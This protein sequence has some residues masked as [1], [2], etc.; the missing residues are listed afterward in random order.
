MK[1]IKYILSVIVILL[2]ISGTLYL[3]YPFIPVVAEQN[4]NNSNENVSEPVEAT[5]DNQTIDLSNNAE[6]VSDKADTKLYHTEWNGTDTYKIVNNNKPFFTQA[7]IEKCKVNGVYQSYEEYSNLDELGRC[8]TATACLGVD[9]QPT[10][11]RSYIG[12]VKPAGWHTVKY[13]EVIA[14]RYL[15]NRTHLIAFFLANEQDNEKNLTTAT[16]YCNLNMTEFEY[17][18]GDY[19]NSHRNNHVLYRITP[20]YSDQNLISEGILMEAYSLEDNG[21]GVCFCVFIY[22][23]QPSIHIC[24]EDGDSWLEE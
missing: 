20:L 14:D 21:S 3:K 10:E 4:T 7:D 1:R 2:G 9:L 17:K 19:L 18:V 22:N 12:N 15:Y 16:R 8:N 13:P 6:Y 11:E 23:V 5:L 24:Y